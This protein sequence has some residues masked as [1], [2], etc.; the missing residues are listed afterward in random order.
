MTIMQVKYSQLIWDFLLSK[1][2]KNI[3]GLPGGPLIFFL[4]DIPKKKIKWNNTG[5]ELQNSFIAQIYGRYTNNV[6]IALSTSGPG[7]LTA[8]S[9]LKNSQMEKNPLLFITVYDDDQ[10]SY[11]FQQ[12]DIINL[13]K[14][15]IENIFVVLNENDILYKL[16]QAYVTSLKEQTGVIYLIKSNMFNKTTNK[17]IPKLITPTLNQEITDEEIIS[18]LLKLNNKN[19]VV[20]IGKGKFYDYQI[21][22]DFLKRTKV[23][24]VV[25]W[26]G[27]FYYDSD[28]FYCGISG[29]LGNHSA[30]YALYNC[31]Y[32]LSIGVNIKLS[33]I[34]YFDK[35]DFIYRN[36][37]KIYSI[38]NSKT[39]FNN[40]A[41]NFLSYNLDKIVENLNIKV[42]EEWAEKL[43]KSNSYL[44][45][46][47]PIYTKLE[48]FSFEISKI[49]L[50]LN[51]DINISTGTGN[52]WYA[53]GKF[54]EINK[55][56]TWITPSNWASIGCG[57]SYGIGIHM[58]NNKPTWIFEGDGGF[59]FSANNML[60]L[61]K[62]KNLPITVFVFINNWYGALCS[63]YE[64]EGNLDPNN[65][66][67]Y[68]Y[69]IELLNKL[70]NVHF[71]NSVKK[72]SN[73]LFLNPISKEL[74]FIIIDLGN[75]PNDSN[76]FE[77]NIDQKY[78]SYLS[79]DKF[80][81]I[82]KYKLVLKAN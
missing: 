45:K 7:I 57:I 32:I 9:G 58:A 80:K 65:P 11:D 73:Y 69:N 19:F 60:Y 8:F 62:H 30:N 74:R 31:D 52:H 75:N 56:N 82:L 12:L 51:L 54:M 22:I 79:N 34:F 55:P 39:M 26:D 29:S 64:Y 53:I 25:T 48:N 23:P 66:T 47:L 43:K 3:F 15:L 42:N 40:N 59:I 27:R 77:I 6:G 1:N 33:N 81:K 10:N 76:V 61:I 78:L 44:L 41:I 16:E 13:S 14:N 35:F 2:I 21:L 46:P 5:N 50:K 18:Q 20:I 49:Y 37:I 38:V 24:Y 72:L 28:V 63:A 68:V 71:F 67:N 4:N 17:N 70:P 36:N